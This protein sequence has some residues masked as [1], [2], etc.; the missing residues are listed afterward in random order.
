MKLKCES[1]EGERQE[2]REKSL[3]RLSL[4]PS[5][6]YL[7]HVLQ[8]SGSCLIITFIALL[9]DTINQAAEVYSYRSF[10]EC[11]QMKK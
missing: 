2:N 9:G 4:P 6:L 8:T 1:G 5:F 3:S 7:L 10:H 11:K